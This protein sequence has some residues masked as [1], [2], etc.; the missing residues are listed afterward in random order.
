[1][2]A[3]RAYIQNS[4]KGF[5]SLYLHGG[6]IKLGGT[7]SCVVALVCE[8]NYAFNTPPLAAKVNRHSLTSITR[9]GLLHSP[10]R[11]GDFISITQ[12][13]SALKKKALMF[14]AS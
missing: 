7:H 13:T 10:S 12:S 11:E 8:L 2:R 4:A 1:M 3:I 6:I 5:R 14:T 9:D